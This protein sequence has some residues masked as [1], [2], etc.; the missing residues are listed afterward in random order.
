MQSH[1]YKYMAL[2]LS[3]ISMMLGTNVYAQNSYYYTCAYL[4]DNWDTDIKVSKVDLTIPAIIDSTELHLPGEIVFKTPVRSISGDKYIYAAD[5]GEASKNSRFLNPIVCNYCIL[6][7]NLNI[8]ISSQIQDVSLFSR[9][10]G[11]IESG[12]IIDY[13]LKRNNL[14]MPMKGRLT[15]DRTNQFRIVDSHE[16]HDS[17]SGYP[18]IGGF[19][20]FNKIS[21]NN[22]RLYWNLNERGMYLLRLDMDRGTLIDSLYFGRNMDY[23]CLFALSPNDSLVYSFHINSNVVRGPTSEQKQS[24]DP[25]YLLRLRA[26]SLTLIDSIPVHYPSLD[27]GYTYAEIGICDW[28]GPYLVYYF[29]HGEDYRYFSPAMLFIFDTRTNEA[30]WLRVGWR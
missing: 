20:Y 15:L 21:E 14:F 27:Y 7:S 13:V 12:L 19:R 30:T 24:I 16:N 28:V 8:L 22:N 17:D 26:N 1:G 29:F 25:S 18:N 2:L 23:S 5:N 10:G 6:D 11:V 9:S 3:I 4:N